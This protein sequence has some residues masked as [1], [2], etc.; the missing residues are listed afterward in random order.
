MSDALV[1]IALALL[2][3]G[4][5]SARA[6]EAAPQAGPKEDADPKNVFKI[7]KVTC[8]KAERRIEVDGKICIQEG[9]IEYLAV[10]AGGKEHESVLT[11]DCKAIDLNLAMIGLGYKAAGPAKKADDPNILRGDPV[12]LSV[13]WA[14]E[15]GKARRIR[16]EELLYNRAT[17][18]AMRQTAW[19]FTGS[20]F[21]RDPDTGKL[22]IDP[23]T[24]RTVFLADL[25]RNLIAIYFD[26]VAIFNS[27]L[28]TANNDLQKT[29]NYY[30][31]NK[32]VCPK[33]GTLVKLVLEPAPKEALEP[34]K[35]KDGAGLLKLDDNG[36]APAPEPKDAP[37]PTPGK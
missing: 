33:P 16:A 19:I 24:K 9:A 32:D 23:E 6:G 14:E 5:V 1:R 3:A 7:G 12:Y 27:P 18:K 20:D 15:G 11:F 37:K 8:H 30:V 26:P 21:A 34:E 31:A 29:I 2:L 28:D 17:K 10:L 35:L 4:T 25:E 13:E 22:Y 36:G